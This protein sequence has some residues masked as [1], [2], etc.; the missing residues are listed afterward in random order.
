MATYSN[1]MGIV[2]SLDTVT[3]PSEGGT[4]TILS[5]SLGET[6]IDF[7]GI[8]S[9]F[10]LNGLINLEV[11]N[12][13]VPGVWERVCAVSLGRLSEIAGSSGGSFHRFKKADDFNGSSFDKS[14]GS[15]KTESTT[16]NLSGL[17]TTIQ[18]GIL[19]R[20]YLPKN[21]RLFIVISRVSELFPS[22]PVTVFWN[23]TIIS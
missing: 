7:L 22:L 16:A 19:G 4:F 18:S 6:F 17:T 5:N 15:S 1:A 10:P 12:V 2:T 23:K 14:N 9:N 21:T 3:I 11:E 20:I 13:V 8:D